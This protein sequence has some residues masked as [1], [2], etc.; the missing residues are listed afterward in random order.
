MNLL[1]AVRKLDAV[2]ANITKAERVWADIEALW[3]DGVAFISEDAFENLASD[4][5]EII[6]SLPKID[7]WKPQPKIVSPNEIARARLEAGEVME[8]DI[9]LNTLTQA[10]DPAK[11]LSIYKHKYEKQRARISSS[12]IQKIITEIDALLEPYSGISTVELDGPELPGRAFWGAL[13]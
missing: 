9:L 10:E 6:E 13:S 4:Y 12:R 1:S 11:Q 5:L 3:P 7:G 2:A 8:I